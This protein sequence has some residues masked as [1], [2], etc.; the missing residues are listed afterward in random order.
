MTRLA[1]ITIPTSILTERL[2]LRP[3][4]ATDAAELLPILE[5]NCAY[6]APWIPARI[7]EP[8]PI[9]ETETRLRGHA[10]DFAANREW[11]YGMFTRDSHL[12][13]G[14][15]SLF[16]RD[17]SR[18]VAFERADRVEIGYWLR[19]D[20]MGQGIVS[21]AVRA[22]LDA[23][24]TVASFTRVEIRCDARN[25]PSAAVPRRLGFTLMANDAEPAALSA[26][27]LDE[28]LQVWTRALRPID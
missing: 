14:E 16:P 7:A 9:P 1:N 27:E 10:S 8:T 4:R 18:R 3:W 24:H 12:I 22:V 23:V 28:Q 19:Q 26:G 2:L 17:A 5:V 13:L 6:L 20:W 11:R 21:E 15:L 25:A